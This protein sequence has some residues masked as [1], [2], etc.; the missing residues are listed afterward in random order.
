MT[1]RPAHLR[2]RQGN[3]ISFERF[4]QL[5]EDRSYVVVARDT[6][7]ASTVVTIWNGHW[8]EALDGS[9]PLFSSIVSVQRGDET[10]LRDEEWHSETETEAIAAH[11]ERVRQLREAMS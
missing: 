8:P 7:G 1:E 2:D 9:G 11:E 5:A 4:A 6:V 3:P 10:T